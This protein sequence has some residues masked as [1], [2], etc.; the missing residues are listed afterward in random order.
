MTSTSKQLHRRAKALTTFYRNQLQKQNTLRIVIILAC[1]LAFGKVLIGL[2]TGI[3][4]GR[5]VKNFTMDFA[6]QNIHSATR[7]CNSQTQLTYGSE[8]LSSDIDLHSTRFDEY[9]QMYRVFLEVRIGSAINNR[10]YIIDCQV[11]PQ[12]KTTRYFHASTRS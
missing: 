5:Q 11:L 10:P 3:N 12:Q 4:G 6:V 1:C 7:L 2:D 8:L 9:D